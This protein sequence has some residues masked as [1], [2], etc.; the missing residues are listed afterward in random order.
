MRL[1]LAILLL[2]A[3]TAQ[4]V[5]PVFQTASGSN[6]SVT[7]LT[8]SHTPGTN[9]SQILIV[10]V[11]LRS[12]VTALV[13]SVSFNGTGLTNL[14]RLAET[15]G[16]QPADTGVWYMLAPVSFAANVVTTVSGITKFSV[17]AVTYSGV[18]QSTPFGAGALV[19]NTTGATAMA[20]TVT[21]TIADSLVIGHV[22][23]N[24]VST[25]TATS[26]QTQRNL[27]TT[28]GGA[29]SSNT[30]SQHDDRAAAVAG[31]FGMFYTS[32]SSETYVATAYEL[33]AS[34]A[35]PT[36]TP[37]PVGPPSGSQSLMGVGR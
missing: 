3:S 1:I 14:T 16:G 25:L 33:I 15:A 20:V 37:T 35:G 27:Q 17:N 22:A 19:N 4:A 5:A 31:A 10:S 36:P 32:G 18:D 12:N 28:G 7:V 9:T 2:L 21:T 13:L 23:T 29:A 24:N 26:P 8:F 30:R 11:S 6:G 34:G